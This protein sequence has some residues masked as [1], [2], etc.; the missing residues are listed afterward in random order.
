MCDLPKCDYD[1]NFRG[2]EGNWKTVI[3]STHSNLHLTNKY[4]KDTNCN[5]CEI[6]GLGCNRV[7]LIFRCVTCGSPEYD[8]P[9]Q[10]VDITR[11]WVWIRIWVTQWHPG[12]R[13]YRVCRRLWHDKEHYYGAVRDSS[14]PGRCLGKCVVML[15]AE[16]TVLTGFMY[17]AV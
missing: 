16:N 8:I 7:I 5:V 17:F 10:W 13:A 15:L 1:Y 3:S 4:Y 2:Y 12:K 6:V 9:K 14:P 11:Q